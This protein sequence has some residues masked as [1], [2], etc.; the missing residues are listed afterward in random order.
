MDVLCACKGI[1]VGLGSFE[2]VGF[3]LDRCPC[4]MV[5]EIALVIVAAR[6]VTKLVDRLG[7]HAERVTHQPDRRIT[8]FLGATIPLLLDIVHSLLAVRHA[9]TMHALEQHTGHMC[10]AT[11]SSQ[12]YSACLRMENACMRAGWKS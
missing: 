11:Q 2:P 6:L 10:L 12:T 8:H 9:Q 7:R 3:D 1:P 5:I 4:R